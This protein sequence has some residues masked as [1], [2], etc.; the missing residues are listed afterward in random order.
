MQEV[1]DK[2]VA[3]DRPVVGGHARLG[4]EEPRRGGVTGGPK[5]EQDRGVAAELVGEGQDRRNA[6]STADE[7]GSTRVRGGVGWSK[8]GPERTG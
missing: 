2:R 6:D 7:H 3:P 8:A 5:A 1:E 4:L